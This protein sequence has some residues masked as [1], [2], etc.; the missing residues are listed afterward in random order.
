MLARAERRVRVM[1]NAVSTL[2]RCRGPCL[3]L[4]DACRNSSLLAALLHP[5]PAAAW[6]GGRCEKLEHAIGALEI[7]QATHALRW[8]SVRHRLGLPP[9]CHLS[10]DENFTHVRV[11]LVYM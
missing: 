7:K 8:R 5:A 11:R 10:E 1:H 2:Q 4:R 9:A 3:Q 6:C